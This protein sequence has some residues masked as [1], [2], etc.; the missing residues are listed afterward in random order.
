MRDDSGFGQETVDRFYERQRREILAR[1]EAAAGAGVARH[2][3]RGSSL[4]PG[5]ATAAV[6]VLGAALLLRPT[7]VTAPVDSADA[8]LRGAPGNDALPLDAYGSWPQT[9][10]ADADAHNAAS[11]G[12]LFDLAEHDGLAPG[13][14]G[15]DA[16]DTEFLAAY[17]TWE[18]S[19]EAS[20]TTTANDAT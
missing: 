4:L 18:E 15:E 16:S 1:L 13:S 10:E 11:V 3:A 20:D 12:W 17:G 19:E 9:L 8:T 7:P 5:L 6:V 14:L 2:P